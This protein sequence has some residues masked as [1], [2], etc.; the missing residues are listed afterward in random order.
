MPS[1]RRHYH[2]T[3]A[4]ALRAHD[5]ALKLGGLLGV[6]NLEMVE[7]AIARPYTG[8]Y[9]TI[10]KKTAALVHS[11]AANHGFA[12]GNKR[13]AVLL[14]HLF[15]DKSGYTLSSADDGECLT[16]TIEV[17]ILDAIEH[18]MSFPDIVDWFRQRIR[19]P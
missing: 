19:R 6:P 11:V 2:V 9:R 3:L 4:D 13:T 1:G 5:E 16:D 14:M 8:H 7:S 18:R 12:D 15:L 17:M 10:A